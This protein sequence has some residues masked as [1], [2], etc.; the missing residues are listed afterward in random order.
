MPT[1]AAVEAAPT[2]IRPEQTARIVQS[3]PASPKVHPAPP[4]GSSS[5]LAKPPSRL[6]VLLLDMFILTIGCS[7][8]LVLFFLVSSRLM[9]LLGPGK[10]DFLPLSSFACLADIFDSKGRA[11]RLSQDDDDESAGGVIPAVRAT[12]THALIGVDGEVAIDA[13]NY[14]GMDEPLHKQ[15]LHKQPLAPLE[16]VRLGGGS[17][18]E[19]LRTGWNASVAKLSNLTGGAV[20]G[21]ASPLSPWAQPQQPLGFDTGG[22]AGGEAG[23]A[24]LP[25]DLELRQLGQT[26]DETKAQLTPRLEK[27]KP[28]REAFGEHPEGVYIA[29]VDS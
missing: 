11:V 4:P 12:P 26:L 19:R 29:P 18:L 21:E 14:L 15:P 20:E 22:E 28:L 7:L 13:P 8:L 10:M 1:A 24:P 27:A 25:L 5:S 2:V 23:G 9:Q 3:E 6:A 16:S 17:L